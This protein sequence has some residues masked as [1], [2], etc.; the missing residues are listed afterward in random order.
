MELGTI[1]NRFRE[2]FAAILNRLLKSSAV[3]ADCFG[4][5][6]KVPK[7]WLNYVFSRPFGTLRQF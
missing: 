6:H 5:K 1:K 2:A 4:E 7:G 3:Y